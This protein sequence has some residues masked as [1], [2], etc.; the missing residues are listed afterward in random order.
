MRTQYVGAAFRRPDAASRVTNGSS[1]YRNRRSQ[2]SATELVACRARCIDE[3]GIAKVLQT[4]GTS[5][6]G[7]GSDL[8]LVVNPAAEFSPAR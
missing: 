6:P 1:A 2:G 5:V 8:D 4:D 7:L 3:P